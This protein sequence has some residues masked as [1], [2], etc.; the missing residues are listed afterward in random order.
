MAQLYIMTIS[1]GQCRRTSYASANMAAVDGGQSAVY[2]PA[3]RGR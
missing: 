2:R 1:V 3:V